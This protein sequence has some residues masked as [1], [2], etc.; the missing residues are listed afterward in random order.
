MAR[1]AA[2]TMKQ[3]D[4]TEAIIGSAFTVLNE[5]RPGLLEKVYESA[6]VIEL[7][8]RGFTIDQQLSF[9]VLY[10][11]RNVDTLVPDLIIERTVIADTKVVTDFHDSHIAQMLGY[12][13]ITQLQVALLL[14]LKY[15]RLQ[16][17]RIV[18]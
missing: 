7:E 9:P 5:L 16:W 11:Q 3:K 2:K 1:I 6:L 12:L 4:T 13:S 17:K 15:A 8:S 14:N 10:K 18:A